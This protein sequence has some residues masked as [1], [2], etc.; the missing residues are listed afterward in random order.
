MVKKLRAILE[1]QEWLFCGFGCQGEGVE[2]K[3]ERPTLSAKV[4]AHL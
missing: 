1:F 3:Y 4:K 2:S